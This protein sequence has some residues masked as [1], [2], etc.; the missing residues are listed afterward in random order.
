MRSENP[1]QNLN[2]TAWINRCDD[3]DN[4]RYCQPHE[5]GFQLPINCK[6]FKPIQPELEEIDKIDEVKKNGMERNK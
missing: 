3:C 4:R 6:H 2:K 1:A 5:T